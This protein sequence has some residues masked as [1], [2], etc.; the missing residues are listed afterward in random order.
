MSRPHDPVT[1]PIIKLR[2]K[3]RVVVAALIE[4][5][6]GGR[7]RVMV[8]NINTWLGGVSILWNVRYGIRGVG[9]HSYFL[10]G[11]PQ[12]NASTGVTEC[13]DET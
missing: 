2:Q 9:I 11:S 6:L 8:I 4:D 5:V 1:S 7:E 13:R 10:V 12:M 3:R